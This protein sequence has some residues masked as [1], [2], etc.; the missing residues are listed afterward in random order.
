M[1]KS[2]D[3]LGPLASWTPNTERL[4]I[5]CTSD[6]KQTDRLQKTTPH[7]RDTTGGRM[8]PPDSPPPTEQERARKFQSLTYSIRKRIHPNPK[9]KFP[10]ALWVNATPTPYP[11]FLLWTQE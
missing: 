1:L 4:S 8:R 11:R 7:A 10:Q 6:Y 5:A 2:R 3:G 9:H